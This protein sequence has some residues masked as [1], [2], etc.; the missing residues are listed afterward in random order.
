MNFKRFKTKT[1]TK[2]K[3]TLMT[4]IREI[5]TRLR[6]RELLLPNHLASNYS[7]SLLITFLLIFMHY[8]N[9]LVPLY[10]SSI[11]A[12]LTK[13]FFP[14]TGLICSFIKIILG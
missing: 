14:Y 3:F 1:I 9:H 7:N 5:K 2:K 6:S 10:R 11:L 4:Q 13:M 12:G 8:Q